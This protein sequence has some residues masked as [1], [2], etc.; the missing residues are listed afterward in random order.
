MTNTKEARIETSTVC[1]YNCVFCPHNIMTRKKEIMS[2]ELF[3]DIISKLPKQITTITLSGM[4][5]A[6]M[7]KGIFDK[8]KYCK[9]L[10]YTVNV[11][12]NGS[13]ITNINI[14]ELVNSGLDSIRISIHSVNPYKYKMITKANDN[15][16]YYAL[17]SPILIAM[18]R[19]TPIKI[20][21]TTDMIEEDEEEVKNIR[22]KYE[23]IVDTIEIWKVHNWSSWKDYRKGKK[24]K[25]TCGRPFN[26]PLQIQVD[27]TIN[28]CCFDYDGK[29]LL[30]DLKS[31]SIEEIFE[32][33]MYKTI[34]DFHKGKNNNSNLLC[35]KCDQLYEKDDSIV[36]Y[37]NKFGKERIGKLSTTYE[38]VE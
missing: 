13:K 8:I 35:N 15:E 11:L 7:D 36:I 28:M 5:E 2:M 25:T 3:K 37:N 6:F 10:G 38:D 9:S 4:G 18:K 14:D 16:I 33:D 26:G 20:I 30:G 24:S 17:A 19:K 23:N 34:V 31:Q 12:S 1:N 22:K 21:I 27:G 29:L 32:S